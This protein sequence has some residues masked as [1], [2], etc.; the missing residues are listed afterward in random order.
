MTNEPRVEVGAAEITGIS[1]EMD[2]VLNA[3]LRRLESAI[4]QLQNRAMHDGGTVQP[5][6]AYDGMIVFSD[7]VSWC[8]D[9]S[10]EPGFYYF[11]NGQWYAFADTNPAKFYM[12][13][14]GNWSGGNNY[15]KGD[16]VYDDGWLM[17]A[18]KDTTDRAAPFPNGPVETDLPDLPTW[19]YN[20][21]LGLVY[22]GHEYVTNQPGFV[23]RVEVWVPFVSENTNTRI[24]IGDITDPDVPE[25]TV[26]EEPV[27]N[28]DAWT[29]I[30]VGNRPYSTG[31]RLLVVIDSLNSGSSSPVS[32]GWTRGPD[33]N[34]AAPAAQQWNRRTQDDTIRINHQDADSVDR[35]TELEGIIAGSTIQF[36]NTNNTAQSVTYYVNTTTPG[37]GFVTYSVVRTDTGAGGEP[38]VGAIC[39]MSADVP[40]PQ[41]TDYVE[42]PNH[43]PT[44]Q[45]AFAA[46]TGVLELS[47][48]PQTR[49]DSAFGVRIDFQPAEVSEDW[50]FMAFTDINTGS[51]GMSVAQSRDVEVVKR[52]AQALGA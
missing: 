33:Q 30:A 46:V 20:Q 35:Q 17:I 26:I 37:V 45:P 9:G 25:L 39:T 36:V 52:L 51:A 10:C 49:P 32:G 18:N 3:R 6:S 11:H 15:D 34:T 47:G 22:S 13:W 43:W 28:V 8:P 29:S 44:N 27:L 31:S 24:I 4:H 7:G 23:Q 50:E 42:I 5:P 12:E 1:P 41:N 14:H 40:V 16:V 19:S 38:P 21:N 2:S 48:V